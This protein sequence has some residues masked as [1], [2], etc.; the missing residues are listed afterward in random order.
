MVKSLS[1]TNVDK[2]GPS[3]E[4]LTSQMSFNAIRENRILA[5][6]PNLQ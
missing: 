4:F 2:S 1:F 6:L 3:R 5:K